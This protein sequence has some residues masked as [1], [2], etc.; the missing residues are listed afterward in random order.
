MLLTLNVTSPPENPVDTSAP[1]IEDTIIVPPDAVTWIV[2]SNGGPLYWSLGTSATP[3][4]ANQIKLGIG[5]PYGSLS[6]FN[7]SASGSIDLSSASTGNYYFH[8]YA[9]NSAGSSATSV[10]EQFYLDNG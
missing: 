2:D 10:S 6:I 5:L 9:T 1:V 7:G 4:T 3:L 8:V